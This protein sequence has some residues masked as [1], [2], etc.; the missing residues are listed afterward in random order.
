MSATTDPITASAE[1]LDDTAA[2]GAPVDRAQQSSDEQKDDQQQSE[3]SY[4]EGDVDA[5]APA[6]AGIRQDLES[7][8]RHARGH[9][10]PVP[11]LPKRR[12][13]QRTERASLSAQIAT[14]PGFTWNAGRV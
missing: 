2:A 11:G 4:G 14:R 5:A 1:P 6:R 10:A 7:C 13:S 8:S 9:R 3:K 12:H